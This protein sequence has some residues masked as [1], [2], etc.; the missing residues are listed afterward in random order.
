MDVC[1]LG[2]I[3]YDLYAV[4]HNRPLA[5]VE[6]FIRRLGGSS[7]NIAVGLARLGL[8]VGI[9]SCVGKDLLAAYLLGFLAREGVDTQH[10]RLVESYNTSLCLTEV[11]PP[12]HFPQVFYRR[13]HENTMKAGRAPRNLSQP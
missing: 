4:E 8:S 5:E 10:V 7:A 11:S 6:H 1:A 3:G 13:Q 9:I 2:R 12:D